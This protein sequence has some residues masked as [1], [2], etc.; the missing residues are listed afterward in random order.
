MNSNLFGS[1]GI[2][3]V[4]G[5]RHEALFTCNHGRS[6]RSIYFIVMKKDQKRGII[7]LRV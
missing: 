3:V 4:A 6:Q 5:E 1:L 7:S 2:S